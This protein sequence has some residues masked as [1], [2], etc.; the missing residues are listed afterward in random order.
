MAKPLSF[1]DFMIVDYRPGEDE[2]T[3]YRAHKRRRGQG[4][5]AD[6]EYASTNPPETSEELSIQGRRKL[7]RS[8]KRR[9]TRLKMARKRAQ[10]RLATK[11][12]LTKRARRGARSTFADMLA[13]KGMKKSEVSVAKKKQIEKRLKQG[14][15]Q[16]RINI[17]QRR[18]MPKKRRQ[19]I[20]RK[21]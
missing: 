4:A 18:L 3:K 19:E 6:A 16:Q 12:V 9:K 7:A 13:G 8:M 20:Q 11:K 15:W 5:G 17:L 2:L 21:R 10:K 14:G 1:A